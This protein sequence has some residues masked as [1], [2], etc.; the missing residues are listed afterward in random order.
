MPAATESPERHALRGLLLA[1]VEVQNKVAL[2]N[3]ELGEV[4]DFAQADKA[5]QDAAKAIREHVLS[6][7]VREYVQL[8]RAILDTPAAPRAIPAEEAGVHL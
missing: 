4:T 7:H 6:D 2:M 5:Y 8:A 1:V 3:A